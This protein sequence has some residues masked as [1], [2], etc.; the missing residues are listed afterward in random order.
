M[1]KKG[2]ILAH[3]ELTD[4]IADRLLATSINVLGIHPGGG[5]AAAE[6]LDELL[7]YLENPEFRRK[8]DRFHDAG[9]EIEYELHALEWL[10]PKSLFAEHP[11]WFRMNEAGERTAD[12]NFC[13]SSKEAL[14]YITDRS[15]YLAR[16][17]GQRSHIYNIWLDD[18]TVGRCECES[19][20]K[21]TPSDQNML[22]SR[23]VLHGLRRYDPEAKQCFLAYH[24]SIKPPVSV[25]AEDGIFLEFAP[26]ARW[27]LTEPSEHEMQYI[28]PLLD[29]FG[30]EDA[31]VLEYWVD[32]SLFSGWKKPPVKCVP[33][34]AAM[35][36]DLDTYRAHGFEYFT[37]FGLYLDDEYAA[38]HGD[39]D[40][41][42]YFD[43]FEK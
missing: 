36:R 15:E 29:Y 19:C 26:I 21:L 25:P 3:T 13:P 17:L 12:K 40:F 31:K 41:S 42:E 10:L 20:K 1:E 18:V 27:S 39:F 32:N 7:E 22:F 37:S 28:R 16:R 4:G 8:L 11:D 2:I 6:L 33:D 24:Q 9:V 34:Y 30:K 5:E 23:A 38:L 43:T 14:D 35:K